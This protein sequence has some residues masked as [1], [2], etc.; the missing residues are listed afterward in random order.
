MI[1]G[2][3]LGKY[4]SFCCHNALHGIR[5]CTNRG[6]KSARIID[7]AQPAE[8]QRA[9]NAKK[10]QTTVSLAYDRTEAA[11]K[12]ARNRDGAT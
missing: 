10:G 11:R 7:V 8:N 2:R 12:A 5:G 3:S 4:Q 6:S 1:L 9:E